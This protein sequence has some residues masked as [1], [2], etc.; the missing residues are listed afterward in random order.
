MAS[1]GTD[2]ALDDVRAQK[3]VIRKEIRAAMKTISAEDIE[4]QSA[5]VWD[6]LVQMD[7]YKNA[8]SVG[9]FLSMPTNE[10]DTS[11]ILKKAIERD[12]KTV[13]VPR[14]GLDFE[15]CD[16]DLIKAET[17]DAD[18]V[19]DQWPRNKWNI[20]E[21]PAHFDCVAGPGDIDLLVVPGVC[22]DDRGG[23]LGQGKGYYD[24]FIAKM[25]A[26]GETKP[27][28]VAVG[29]APQFVG[30]RHVP[31]HEHDFSMNM[32]VLPESTHDFS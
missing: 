22:F 15:K 4:I 14:V 30:D 26:G 16:M 1:A 7:Q 8:V 13:Y 6:R 27:L 19:W 2:D 31:M 5:M 9:L 17:K 23:R 20:P 3:K 18:D 25:K 21:P 29:L 32:L 10:I 24:R 12:D 28:L 11:L